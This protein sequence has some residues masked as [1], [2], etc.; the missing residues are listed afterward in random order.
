MR[1]AATA[2]L[3]VWIA[4]S[5]ELIVVVALHRA[6][7]TGT[8]EAGMGAALL[9]PTALLLA[10]PLGLV[11]ALLHRSI[12]GTSRTE[13]WLATAIAG[14]SAGTIAA[15]VATGR[16]L[17]EPLLR[18]A[19]ATVTALAAA[20]LMWALHP[21]LAVRLRRAPRTFAAW[22]AALAVL[23]ELGNRFVLVRLYPAFHSGLGAASLSLAAI[24]GLTILAR[25]PKLPSLRGAAMPALAGIVLVGSLALARPG[26]A[27]LAGFDN[28]RLLVSDH[29]PM[30]SDAVRVAALLSPPAPF[31]A[32]DSCEADPTSCGARSPDSAGPSF[33]GRD[34]VLVSVDALRAD[35]VGAY[36]YSRATTPRIDALARDAVVFDHA[37]CPTPHTSYSVT[38]M[39]TGKYMRPLLLQ[40]AGQ[41]SDTL[42]TYLRTYG[43]KTAAFYPPAVFFID[44]ARFEPFE[45]SH[46][47]FEYRKVEFLEGEGRVRQIDGYLGRLAPDQRVFLWVHL[48]GPHEPYEA[49]AAHEFGARDVDRYD[50][51][52]AAADA[53]V[54]DIVDHVRRARPNAVVIV[55]AD[56]G[57][58]FGE[59]GGRYHGTTV[60]EEQVR[61]PL[62]VSAPGLL[63][64]HRVTSVAQTIDLLPTILAALS[65]PPS[66][67]IRGRAL[68]AALLAETSSPGFAFAETEESALLAEGSARLVCA[69]KLGACRLFDIARD[70]GER[71]DIV[72]SSRERFDKMRAELSS[73]GASHGRFEREGLRVETGRGWPPPILRGIAGDADAALDLAG[74]LDDSDREIRRKAA[75]LLFQLRRPETVSALTL[76][77][78]RDEDPVVRRFAALA[79]TRLGEAAPL[80]TELLTD[81]DVA[82]RRRAALALGEAGDAHA[83]PLLVEW[84]Q[85]GG[86][87]DHARAVE[88]LG[89]LGR[90]R[91]KDSVW[92]LVHSLGDVRL[93]PRIAETLATIGDASARGPLVA[94]F[95]GERFQTTRIAIAD[96]LVALGA[97][98]ELA[99]PLV[100]FLGVPDPLPG[101]VGYAMRAGILE[102]VGGPEKKTLARLA[103][104]SDVGVRVQV[105]VP[106]AGVEG[107]GL[108]V[109]VRAL[110]DAPG[111]H[112]RIGRS[113]RPLQLDDK[114]M[115]TKQREAPTIHDRDYVAVAVPASKSPVEVSA[116]LPATVGTRPGRSIEFILFAEHGVHVQ[117]VAVVP[118][119]PELPPPPAEPWKPSAGDDS[120]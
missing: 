103:A 41:D 120:E 66:P 4:A 85:H 28:F 6:E 60:Y 110:A 26:A 96:A 13:R 48:F 72:A 24:A 56:H 57:E 65:I 42:A 16:H 44:Q 17:A 51:E 30:L 83:G 82:W 114:G 22:A 117:A 31:E 74:L 36:G 14:I 87:D 111:G 89:A 37:Y 69:R 19:F 99:R 2:L 61:V 40:G 50:S 11:G 5:L 9:A 98:E 29:A 8:W 71:E 81:P 108:R 102:Q 118:L 116:P 7:L 77:L 12:A 93:R 70:P 105:V 53:T 64:A 18:A 95:A 10:A 80:A 97:K 46:F 107:T 101:G 68:G 45:R 75:E 115:P 86:K 35:H 33:A 100:R 23:L 25:P 67:R 52:I 104:Q 34:I 109:L 58:E 3:S 20:G 32:G 38:S 119:V 78:G 1:A 43:Y 91:F 49:H 76:A 39:M 59:H 112:V 94:A 90:I 79:L 62:V 73:L 47:G 92:T 27:A 84:W 54:G 15:L 21:W 113:Q 88:I 63:P 106:H 55:T